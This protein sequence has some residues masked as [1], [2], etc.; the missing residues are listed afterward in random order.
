MARSA[1]SS[2]EASDDSYVADLPDG[3]FGRV[4]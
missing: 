2:V 4:D 1:G 3:G